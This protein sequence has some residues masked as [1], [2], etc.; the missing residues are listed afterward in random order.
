MGTYSMELY[1][2]GKTWVLNVVACN[3]NPGTFEIQ[4]T[5]DQADEMKKNGVPVYT[6]EG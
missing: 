3:S 5:D 4:V 1:H 2:N 6:P